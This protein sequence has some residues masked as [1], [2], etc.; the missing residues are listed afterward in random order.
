MA[1]FI[2]EGKVVKNKMHNN[3]VKINMKIAFKKYV[4]FKNITQTA[5][6]NIV[7]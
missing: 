2:A 5:V 7:F 6:I 1:D 3:V 4:P